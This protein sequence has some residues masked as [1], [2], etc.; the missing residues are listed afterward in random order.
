MDGLAC[1]V[2]S[3]LY[4][5]KVKD[6]SSKFVGISLHFARTK[7]KPRLVLNSLTKFVKFW[8][9]KL[10]ALDHNIVSLCIFR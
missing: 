9:A 2:I 4:S 10:R 7:L 3:R 5:I 1:G 6:K 8:S